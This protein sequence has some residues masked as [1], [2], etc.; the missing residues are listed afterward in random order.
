MVPEMQLKFSYVYDGYG[1]DK[2]EI[3][4][5]FSAGADIFRFAQHPNRL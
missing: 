3:R 2:Q 4:V 1:L 5:Q